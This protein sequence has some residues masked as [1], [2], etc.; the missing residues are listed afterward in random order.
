MRKLAL[1]ILLLCPA[2]ASAVTPQITVSATAV[3][4]LGGNQTISITCTLIDP[5]NT[6]MMRII[7]TNI[8]PPGTVSTVTPGSTATVGPIWGSDV[9][10]NAQGVVNSTYYRVSVFT[11]SNGII[12]STASLSNFYQ[13]IGSGTVDLATATPVAPTFLTGPSGNVVIPGTLTVSTIGPSSSQQHTLPAVASDTVALLAA[14]QTLA[15]K[16]L[17]SPTSTGTDSGTE[18]LTNKTLT[19]PVINGTPTG[20]GLP[21][22]TFKKGSGGANYTSTSTF[23]VNVDTTNLQYVVTIPTGW[24]LLINSSGSG[25]TATAVA[26]LFVAITDGGSTI[27]QMQVTPSAASVFSGWALNGIIAGDG[28]SHTIDLAFATSNASDAATILNGSSIPVMTFSLTP[29]N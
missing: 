23:L 25:T 10:A 8:I 9:I 1:L 3:T 26:N 13:F 27:S 14:T 6:G 5:G 29:S 24:K 16:T 7:G 17:T 20:T 11:V 18:T 12:A 4:L 28:N 22:M 15:A 2:L 21:T 19:S